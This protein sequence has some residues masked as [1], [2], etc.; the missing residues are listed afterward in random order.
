MCREP[1]WLSFRNSERSSV[2]GRS[3]AALL[4][5]T[6]RQMPSSSGLSRCKASEALVRKQGGERRIPTSPGAGTALPCSSFLR[7]YPRLSVKRYAEWEVRSRLEQ[8]RKISSAKGD[9]WPRSARQR[10][11]QRHRTWSRPWGGGYCEIFMLYLCQPMVSR[12]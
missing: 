10:S 7:C 11:S 8:E 5:V 1:G 12:F 9:R 2:P 6:G 3:R 4:W